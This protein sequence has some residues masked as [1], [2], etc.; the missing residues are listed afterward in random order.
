MVELK[1]ALQFNVLVYG[2]TYIVNTGY[3]SP[4]LMGILLL[5]QFPT[6]R[7]L[8][9]VPGNL[10]CYGTAIEYRR[11][12]SKSELVLLSERKKALKN[13]DEIGSTIV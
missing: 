9:K 13:R 5:D 11:T 1:V 4:K 3:C 2:M 10:K 6:I 7:I 12:I 8:K